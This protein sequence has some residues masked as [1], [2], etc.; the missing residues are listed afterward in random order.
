MS[1]RIIKRLDDLVFTQ[2]VTNVLT[3]LG[4]ADSMTFYSPATFAGT[5]TIQ[6]AHNNNPAS[7]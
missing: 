2:L 1:F 3:D 5:I 6:V 4:D 7:V